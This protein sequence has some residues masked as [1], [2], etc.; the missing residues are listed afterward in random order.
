M[1]GPKNNETGLGLATDS[2]ALP[3]GIRQISICVY[4]QKSSA[5]CLNKKRRC[6]ICGACWLER[7]LVASLFEQGHAVSHYAA[8]APHTRCSIKKV[9]LIGGAIKTAISGHPWCMSIQNQSGG[10]LSKGFCV[11]VT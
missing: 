5:K 11:R 7:V 3:R 9:S 6:V 8:S 2:A 1:S 10:Y 4:Y